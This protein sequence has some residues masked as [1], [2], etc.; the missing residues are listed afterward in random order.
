[1]ENYE[2]ISR[3]SLENWTYYFKW[4][5]EA[6]PGL[7][8]L[9]LLCIPFTIKMLKSTDQT[10]R[11]ILISSLLWIFTFYIFFSY[12]DNKA[13]RFGTHWLP[14]IILITIANLAYGTKNYILNREKSSVALASILILIFAIPSAMRTYDEGIPRMSHIDEAMTTILEIAEPKSDSNCISYMGKFKQVFTQSLRR[15]DQDRYYHLVPMNEKLPIELN[16]PERCN[17]IVLE[18]SIDQDQD[19]LIKSILSRHNY[20]ISKTYFNSPK[21]KRELLIFREATL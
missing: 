3:L 9:G 15:L 21:L 18:I 19:Q 16:E 13:F 12:F 20:N 17:T 7:S 1:M 10:V 14:P 2:G 8:I 6:A 4:I 11:F 5:W